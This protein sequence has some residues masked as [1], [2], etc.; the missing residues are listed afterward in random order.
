MAGLTGAPA[1]APRPE[2]ASARPPRP[3]RRAFPRPAAELLRELRQPASARRALDDLAAEGR[4]LTVPDVAALLDTLAQ[5]PLL[6]QR[7]LAGP[8][9]AVL[10][11]AAPAVG[12]SELDRYLDVLR[13]AFAN[14]RAGAGARAAL[15]R[16]AT[17][18]GLSSQE[19][20]PIR[21]KVIG[22]LAE[23]LRDPSAT[24][25]VKDAALVGLAK[26]YIYAGRRERELLV[27]Q[28]RTRLDSPRVPAA[29][30]GP[31]EEL[32]D[33]DARVARRSP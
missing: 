9:A 14:E 7:R 23:V 1:A 4:A 19:Q 10:E 18:L 21:D 13:A 29:V 5:E 33:L 8:V 22:L 15:A 32:L 25:Q 17:A 16:A 11:A 31:L 28:A 26:L 3:T 20:R 6:Q 2:P 24:G 30:R 12:Q 27:S